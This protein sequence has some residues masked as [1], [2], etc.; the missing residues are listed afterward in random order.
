MVSPL[1]ILEG[2]KLTFETTRNVE[3]IGYKAATLLYLTYRHALRLTGVRKPYAPPVTCVYRTPYG[4]FKIRRGTNDLAILRAEQEI[5]NEFM[6]DGDVFVDAGAHIGKYSIM[7]S[8]RFKKIIAVEANP[9]N[10]QTLVENIKLNRAYNVKP[11]Q[12]A[13]W[14]EDNKNLNIFTPEVNWGSASLK[15]EFIEMQGMK[16]ISRAQVRTITLNT[17]LELEAVKDIDLMKLDLEGAEYEALQGLN[18]NRHTV[19]KMIFEALNQK[20]ASRII[21]YLQTFNYKI[22]PTRHPN[23]WIAEK[24]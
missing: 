2:L 12:R 20:Y 9:I 3:G 8:Q 15:K 22:R 18:L 5:W 1:K 19:R 7:L 4:R 17:L 13:L 6:V 16:I 10:F 14:S 23:Y 21:T 24:R 11:I